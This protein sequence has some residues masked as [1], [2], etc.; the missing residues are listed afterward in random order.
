MNPLKKIEHKVEF[1]IKRL[2]AYY[3]QLEFKLDTAFF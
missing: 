3:Y 2:N 1:L